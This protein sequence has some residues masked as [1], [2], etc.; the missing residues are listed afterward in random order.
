MSEHISGFHTIRAKCA[1]CDLVFEL[2]EAIQCPQCT[3][4]V[5]VWAICRGVSVKPMGWKML[6][7]VDRYAAKGL[8]SGEVVYK[9][10]YKPGGIW[11]W[12][13]A[14]PE[15]A[16]ALDKIQHLTEKDRRDI[17]ELDK[18]FQ[19]EDTREGK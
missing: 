6:R 8:L 17:M 16:K 15:Q 9:V 10:V 13:G 12:H 3:S 5:L 11:H 2:N 1:E 7:D 18:L 4:N 19:L 14:T